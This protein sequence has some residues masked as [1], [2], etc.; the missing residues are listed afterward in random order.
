MRRT[1][2]VIFSLIKVGGRASEWQSRADEVSERA[3]R[4]SAH[5]SKGTV[6]TYLSAT[7]RWERHLLNCGVTPQ[8]IKD[9]PVSDVRGLVLLHLEDLRQ[10]DTLTSFKT[11]QYQL[12]FVLKA[13]GADGDAIMKSDN[14]RSMVA[15]R[16]SNG[17]T[18]DKVRDLGTIP[19]CREIILHAVK[20]CLEDFVSSHDPFHLAVASSIL[21]QAANG[22]RPSNATTGGKEEEKDKDGGSSAHSLRTNDDS[23]IHQKRG[24]GD[25]T[26][27]S[28]SNSYVWQSGE[29][30][31]STRVVQCIS[32]ATR[33]TKRNDKGGEGSRIELWDDPE[34]I[35]VSLLFHLRLWLYALNGYS[36]PE[37]ITRGKKVFFADGEELFMRTVMGCAHVR[38]HRGAYRAKMVR[39]ND[40]ALALRRG[41]AVDGR[42]NA[43]ML[44][45]ISCKS[46]R[47]YRVHRYCLQGIPTKRIIEMM[48]WK[49]N[50]IGYYARLSSQESSETNERRARGIVDETRDVTF[51]DLIPLLVRITQGRPVCA[52]GSASRMNYG[53]VVNVGVGPQD[54]SALRLPS[55]TLVELNAHYVCD[56]TGGEGEDLLEDQRL[57]DQANDLPQQRSVAVSASAPGSADPATQD[58]EEIAGA[59]GAGEDSDD[60]G[61][62]NSASSASEHDEPPGDEPSDDEGSVSGIDWLCP[63]PE[64]GDDDTMETDR[65]YLRHV[66]HSCGASMASMSC[67]EDWLWISG[68]RW[69]QF[70]VFNG[71]A[72]WENVDTL[73][74]PTSVHGLRDE[75]NTGVATTSTFL[76]VTFVIGFITEIEVQCPSSRKRFD[77]I[78]FGDGTREL[79]PRP[80]STHKYFGMRDFMACYR[81]M[82]TDPGMKIRARLA[83]GDSLRTVFPIVRAIRSLRADWLPEDDTWPWVVKA[84]HWWFIREQVASEWI[85]REAPMTNRQVDEE[86]RTFEDFTEVR[87]ERDPWWEDIPG[88]DTDTESAWSKFSLLSFSLVRRGIPDRRPD[89][90][91]EMF[92][93]MRQVYGD[94]LDVEA[95]YPDTYFPQG[96]PPFDRYKY[97]ADEALRRRG[98]ADGRGFVALRDHVDASRSKLLWGT[99]EE[100]AD[101]LRPPAARKSIQTSF[102]RPF[103]RA[104][105]FAIEFLSSGINM[106]EA[107]LVRDSGADEFFVVLCFS[108][109]LDIRLKSFRASL[110]DNIGVQDGGPLART[111]RDAIG[112]GSTVAYGSFQTFREAAYAKYACTT[113][114][115]QR[116]GAPEALTDRI[117]NQL[118]LQTQK[119]IL[120]FD[121]AYTL[122]G[123]GGMERVIHAD[124]QQ[125]IE[126]RAREVG[127]SGCARLLSEGLG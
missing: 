83:W 95:C 32:C 127:Y 84:P 77:G 61:E 7:G 28:L 6:K 52:P 123:Y 89:W 12:R 59:A 66:C 27:Y 43:S 108:Y 62:E 44:E 110:F 72:M 23:V 24:V 99:R 94:L 19:V 16:E 82:E 73:G 21:T 93:K 41:A 13:A 122:P 11:L 102:R 121:S 29:Y 76:R 20:G 117:V 101:Y 45:R 107:N 115:E 86:A 85:S 34:N 114:W 8:S 58:I 98:G 78:L 109:N 96:R 71:E 69:R 53:L 35:Y 63:N 26:V 14:V 31:N 3:L 51:D 104:L 48:G 106:S 100:L 68:R 47:E 119:I 38:G 15:E 17:R 37:R 9:R 87:S 42:L 39:P 22:V 1:C 30:M 118:H 18:A 5:R 91:T 46:L 70:N 4:K 64:C 75:G 80:Y 54:F 56:L 113:D 125:T 90:A 74:V 49:S 2:N 67:D 111:V 105:D 97:V 126:D 120:L 57:F 33:T 88:T 103:F 65:E 124:L 36:T 112:R 79:F 55:I 92:E 25:G 60:Q 10:L 116:I 50:L 40:V 81:R